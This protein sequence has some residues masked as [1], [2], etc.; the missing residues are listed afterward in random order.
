MPAWLGF[1]GNILSAIAKLAGFFFAWKSGKDSV[2][3]DVNEDAAE[4]RKD[5]LDAAVNSPTSAADLADRLRN[6]DPF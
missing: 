5:M 1:F 2:R 4:T 6:G 3:A